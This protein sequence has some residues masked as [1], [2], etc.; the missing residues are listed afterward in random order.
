MF[1]SF[2]IAVLDMREMTSIEIAFFILSCY[3]PYIFCEA[4][5]SSGV[6]SIFVA[7]S[8]MRNYAFYSL[9]HYGK[10]T[11]EY[12]VDTVGFTTENFVFAYLGISIPLTLKEVNYSLVGLGIGSLMLS[13]ALAIFFSTSIVN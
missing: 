10:I 8:V 9:G 1:I 2:I 6:I 11:I 12:L 5:G 4:V 3:F 7:G 13:R